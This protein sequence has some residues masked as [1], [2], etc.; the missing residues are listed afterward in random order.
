M[1]GAS[2]MSMSSVEGRDQARARGGAHGRAAEADRRRCAAR[3]GWCSRGPA[4]WR[5]RTT[6]CRARPRATPALTTF[7]ASSTCPWSTPASTAEVS[8]RVSSVGEIALVGD[9]ERRHRAAAHH[10]DELAE[11]AGER[12]ERPEHRERLGPDRRDVHGRGDDAAGEG[13]GHLLGHD[14]AGAVLGLLGRGA[15]VRRH[16]DAGQAEERALGDRLLREDVDARAAEV[17]AAEGLHEG[18]LVRP[19][20]RAR[21]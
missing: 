7:T 15:Q 5:S 11:L 10:A 21:R 18:L 1:C 9:L 8:M 2:S 12:Q 3:G 13:G 16:D 14:H 4:G 19:R 17:A 20:R 6:R